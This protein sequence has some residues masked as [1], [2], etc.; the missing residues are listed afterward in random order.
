MENFPSSSSVSKKR[1]KWG[2]GQSFELEARSAHVCIL[3][4]P[5]PGS[6]FTFPGFQLSHLETRILI[7]TLEH[8]CK[9]DTRSLSENTPGTGQ[10]PEMRVLRTQKEETHLRI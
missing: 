2:G 9:D 7:T 1:E 5:P 8:Q 10:C 4:L 6:L 3:I